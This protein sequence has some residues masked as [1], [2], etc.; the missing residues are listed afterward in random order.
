MQKIKIKV[1]IKNREG[2]FSDITT[3]VKDEKKETITYQEDY[4]TPTKVVYFYKEYKLVR[5]NDE[6]YMVFHFS[7]GKEV[8]GTYFF[9]K[10]KKLTKIPVFVEKLISNENLLQVL[11]KIGEEEFYYAWEELK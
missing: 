7:E 1:E 8:M 6:I 4:G 9:R 2:H 3:A 5:E 11:Y 10:K